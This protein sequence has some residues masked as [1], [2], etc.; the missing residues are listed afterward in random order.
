MS[1]RSID[2]QELYNFLWAWR[3]RLIQGN[4]Y[5]NNGEE[6]GQLMTLNTILYW[7]DDQQHREIRERPLTDGA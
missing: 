2:G 6:F 1:H 4:T 5:T 3:R 7:I